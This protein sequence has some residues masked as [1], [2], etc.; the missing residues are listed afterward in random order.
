MQKMWVLT[1]KLVLL[2]AENDVFTLKT[3]QGC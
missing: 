1:G 2:Y 3:E